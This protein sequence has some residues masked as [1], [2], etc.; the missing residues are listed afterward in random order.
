MQAQQFSFA[1]GKARMKLDSA[2]KEKITAI[3]FGGLKHRTASLRRQKCGA[4]KSHALLD[5]LE[6]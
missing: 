1:S 6:G 3:N 4:L 5:S 2:F